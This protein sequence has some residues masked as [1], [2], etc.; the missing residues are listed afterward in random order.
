MKTIKVH[1]KNIKYYDLHGDDAR[2]QIKVAKIMNEHMKIKNEFMK[3][4]KFK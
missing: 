2:K 4:N 3:S 1:D